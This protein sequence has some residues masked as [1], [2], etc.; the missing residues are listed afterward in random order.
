M[1]LIVLDGPEKA[2]KT[3]LVNHICE[4]YG[5]R[6]VHWSYVKSDV[7]YLAPLQEAVASDDL[8]IWDRGWDS[9]H[10]YGSVLPKDIE[11][12]SHRLFIDPWLGEWLYGRAVQTVGVRAILTSDPTYRRNRRDD[13]DLPCDPVAEGQAY[14]QYARTFGWEVLYNTY[15]EDVMR[16]H[17]KTLVNHAYNVVGQAQAKPPVY[18]GPPNAPVVVVG[19]EGNPDNPAKM[20]GCWLPFTSRLTTELGRALGPDAFQVGWTNLPNA[21]TDLLSG[22]RLVVA[23]GEQVSRYLTNKLDI[24]HVKIPHPAFTYRYDPVKTHRDTVEANFTRTV[25]LAL[26]QND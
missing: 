18:A 4:A 11:R 13:T 24:L 26:Y 5:A 10:V 20:R 23:C 25:R 15:T 3:T 17:A 1:P 8:V 2:G 7:E 12:R 21:S 14:V 9:L 6:Q 19:E 22:R 16:E